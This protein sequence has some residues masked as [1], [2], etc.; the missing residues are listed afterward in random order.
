MAMISLRSGGAHNAAALADVYLWFTNIFEKR[1][2]FKLLSR[3]VGL[4]FRSFAHKPFLLPETEQVAR[5]AAKPK[6][7]RSGQ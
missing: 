7:W 6:G 5:N 3:Y 1:W 4:L 2:Q